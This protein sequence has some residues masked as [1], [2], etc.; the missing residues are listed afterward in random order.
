VNEAPEFICKICQI[1]VVGATPTL[2]K[3]SHLFCGD[4]ITEWFAR[5]PSFRSWAQVAKSSGVEATVP[6]PVCKTN[7]RDKQDLHPL[8][9]SSQKSECLL[10]WRMLCSLKIRCINHPSVNGKGS[11]DWVGEYRNYEAHAQMCLGLGPRPRSRQNHAMTAIPEEASPPTQLS[12]SATR[13]A[14]EPTG[15]PPLPATAPVVPPTC[16]HCAAPPSSPEQLGVSVD[17][18]GELVLRLERADRSQPSNGRTARA[19]SSPHDSPEKGQPDTRSEP[20]TATLGFEPNGANQIRVTPGEQLRVDAV[21]PSGWAFGKNLGTRQEGWFPQYV[22]NPP[23][24]TA[25]AQAEAADAQARAQAEAAAA[26]KAEAEAKAQAAARQTSPTAS[27][28]SSTARP[29]QAAPASPAVAPSHEP[30]VTTITARANFQAADPSQLNL[31]LGDQVQVIERHNTGWTYGRKNA[32][33]SE[34]WFPDWLLTLTQKEKPAVERSEPARNGDL[35][36]HKPQVG[37]LGLVPKPASTLNANAPVFSPNLSPMTH[38]QGVNGAG[39]Q[40]TPPRVQDGAQPAKAGPPPFS[41]AHVNHGVSAGSG[42]AEASAGF[43]PHA[44]AFV[45][46]TIGREAP[47]REPREFIPGAKD[48]DQRCAC[49]GAQCANFFKV[50]YSPHGYHPLCSPQCWQAFAKDK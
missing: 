3:C 44:P 18:S 9:S 19:P 4:C 14:R 50:I 41:L 35:R 31:L 17:V 40:F 22:V 24:E 28:A 43:N 6:C 20:A 42:Y 46:T 27:A 30:E 25:T 1:H 37:G 2:T 34:G 49:C 12:P 16:P 36:E 45:P 33:D 38:P 7:L 23:Q 5:Q 39:G 48:G 11:C 21:H 13:L 26:A 8:S 29:A 15:P 10:L 32:D 47:A